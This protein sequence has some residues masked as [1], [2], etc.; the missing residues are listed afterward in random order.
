MK[1]SKLIIQQT[2]VWKFPRYYYSGIKWELVI[3]GERVIQSKQAASIEDLTA[4]HHH[5]PQLMSRF[6]HDG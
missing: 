4:T 1:I 5:H 6:V 3:N 2:W